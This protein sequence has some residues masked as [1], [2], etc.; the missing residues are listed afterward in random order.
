[1]R[2][3]CDRDELERMVPMSAS[4]PVCR[5]VLAVEGEYSASPERFRGDNERGVS[6]IHRMIRVGVHEIERTRQ[7]FGIEPP[8]GHSAG[9]YEI[10][11]EVGA[12]SRRPEHVKTSVRTDTVVVSGVRLSF[13]RTVR[14]NQAFA[15]ARAATTATYERSR[16]KVQTS[17]GIL[18][19]VELRHQNSRNS[20][21]NSPCSVMCSFASR[22]AASFSSSHAFRS[23]RESRARP[24][25]RAPRRD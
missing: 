10:S 5:K 21:L 14:M 22:N 16:S 9:A 18:L 19:D 2:S 12:A 8:H 7:R 24:L 11:D 25:L 17:A 23:A 4:D 20:S 13:F 3:G 15:M 1:M 6:E